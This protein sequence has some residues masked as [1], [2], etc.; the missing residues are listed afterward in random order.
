MK[1][2]GMQWVKLQH[3]WQPGHDGEAVRERIEIVHSQGMKVLLSIVS[4]PNPSSIDFNSF[5]NFLG[6]VAAENPDAIEI[7]SEQNIDFEWPAGQISAT[8]YVNNM[9]R[10]GYQRIKAVDP[11]ILVISGGPAPTGFFGGCGAN[12]CDDKPYVEEMFRAGAGDYLDCVGIHYN[13]GIVPPSA[14][15]GD[16]RGNS[17]FYT[18]YYPTMVSTYR[19]IIGDKPLCFTELGYLSFDG[20]DTVPP[21]F[22][23]AADTSV[24]E[25]AQW[26]GEVVTL[27]KNDPG[28]LMLIIFN[29]DIESFGDDPQSAFSMIRPDGSCPACWTVQSA[30]SR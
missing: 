21:R 20:F 5:V 18:R 14:T 16:P 6:A 1:Q 22:A 8:S 2:A 17:D 11:N 13:E 4:N 26:L 29:M 27:T 19:E 15:S 30:A 28:V 3:K 10:P 23:W 7:W 12:G 24:Q 25:Q 9:L